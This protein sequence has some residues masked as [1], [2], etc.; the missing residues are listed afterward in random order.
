ML[1]I[2]TK[3]QIGDN[4]S[5]FLLLTLWAVVVLMLMCFDSPLHHIYNRVDSAWFFMCGKAMMNGLR[6]YVDFTDCKGPLLW[7]IYGVAYLISPRNYFGVY[8]L[9]CLCYGGVLYYNY[10]TAKLLL[11]DKRCSLLVAMLMPWFYFLTWFCNDIRAEDFCNLPLSASL[12]YLLHLLYHKE[13]STYSMR[14]YC[15]ALGSSFMALVL[16]KWNVAIMQVLMIAAALW[17]YFRKEHK[18]WEPLKWVTAGMTIVALPFLVY[19]AVMGSLSGF[20]QEYFVNTMLE[21]SSNDGSLVAFWRELMYSWGEPMKQALLLFICG[22]GWLVG[23]QLP[24]WRQLPWIVGLWFYLLSTPCNLP[25]YYSICYL[26]CI[27]PLIYL[28]SLVKRPLKVRYMAVAVIVVICWGVFENTREQSPLA[29][30]TRWCNGNDSINYVRMQ[31][32]SQSINGVP[33]PR[34]LYFFCSDYGFGI[35]QECLPAGKYY[36][37]QVGTTP[38]M[39]QESVDLLISG[40][41]DFVVVVRPEFCNSIGY[42]RQVIESY[43]YQQVLSL[44]SIFCSNL[45]RYKNV[46]LYRKKEINK[47]SF[48]RTHVLL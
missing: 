19:L 33:K 41:P 17:Y 24:Y 3:I 6:P 46:V 32:I 26:F 28:L 14:R 30:V 4:L 48:H 16:I 37:Q 12:Y 15:L 13:G 43:G 10:K 22:G 45:Q 47:I 21:K 34:I 38:S 23:R 39:E 18:L 36:A 1:W 20:V 40:K 8:I 9:A 29:K 25:Y 31:Q 27:F 35:E 5:L 44:D 42:T 7:L 2:K 11:D